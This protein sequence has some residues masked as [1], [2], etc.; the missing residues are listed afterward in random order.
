MII[1]KLKG[2]LG[3]QLFQYAF[4]TFLCKQRNESLKLDISSL[5][6][7]KDTKREFK[8]DKFNIKTNI[9]SQKEINKYKPSDFSDFLHKKILRQFNIGWK[10]TLLQSKS[11]YFEGY[12]Q[13]YKY[14]TAIRNQLLSEITLKNTITN[15][16]QEFLEKIKNS[17]SIAIHIRHGDFIKNK[18]HGICDINYYQN[19]IEIIKNK[20]TNPTLFIFSDD[21]PWVKQNLKTDLP[22]FY[23]FQTDPDEV[24]ELMLMSQCQHQ[25]IA[26]ST[27]SWW[28]AWLNQNPNKI[29]IAPKKWNNRY[30]KYYKYLLPDEWEVI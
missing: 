14:F 15:I 23:I 11:T 28:G 17:N 25:I 5:G 6:S 3:N 9:A 30:Q 21:I 18:S 1:V 10:S 12:W 26:N 29:V 22:I 7:S 13:S 27:F 16:Y 24:Q 19:A 2:G 20:I 4:G 8:L